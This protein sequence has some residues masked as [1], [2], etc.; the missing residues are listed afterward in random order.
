M[1]TKLIML[2]HGSS[3]A[4]WS[5]AFFIMTQSVR[6]DCADAVL[7]FM[8]LSSPDLYDACRSAAKEGY[9]AIRVLPLFLAVG[10]HLKKDVP[11]MIEKLQEE[12][13]IP[14]KLLPPIGEH[15][16]LRKA[17]HEIVCDEVKPWLSSDLVEEK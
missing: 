17:I 12:L 5:D 10:R 13:S 1:K 8:E 7:A 14:I 6:S 2:A 11:A 4:S 16:A 3:N 9:E 15:P